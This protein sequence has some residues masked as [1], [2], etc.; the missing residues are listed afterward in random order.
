MKQAQQGQTPNQMMAA[1]GG[2]I[3]YNRGRVVNPG[4]YAG[5]DGILSTIKN[6]PKNLLSGFGQ[7]FSGETGAF[8]GGDQE[9]INEILLE[10]GYGIDL[11]TETISMIIDMNKKGMGIDEIVSLTGSDAN[12][13]TSIIE[14]LNMK[15]DGGRIGYQGG[16]LVDEDIN[17]QGPGFDVNENMEMAEKSPFEMR[18]DE[19][20]DT[21]MSW[22]EA[23]DIASDEF[24]QL[25]EGGEE[26]FSEEGIASLV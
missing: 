19:L 1:N 12:T 4:G 16:E 26:S 13:V 15:A 22:Q 10:K 11:P 8:L 25:A 20:M 6:F 18:I 2:R 14:R 21:G 23:Y 5:D 17:I 9:K 3:G 24:N 7:I